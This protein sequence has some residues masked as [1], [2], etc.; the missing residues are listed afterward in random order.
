MNLIFIYGPPATGKLTIATELAKATG[1]VLFHNHLTL[2]L[3][4]V[5]LPDFDDRLFEL[6]RKLRLDMMESAAKNERNLIFTYVFTG[7]DEEVG[8]VHDVVD[9]VE[10]SGGRVY[11]VQL[12]A[13]LDVI[14]ERVGNESRRQ[15]NKIGDKEELRLQLGT[16]DM[17]VSVPQEN[18]LKIDTSVS[19]PQE[20]SQKIVDTFLG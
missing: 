10:Q 17:N 5:I 11:F 3:A 4:R 18:V 1:Y 9:T 20:S 16:W 19:A 7:D 15:H 6:S 12:V 8:F 2:N 13:P 14:L